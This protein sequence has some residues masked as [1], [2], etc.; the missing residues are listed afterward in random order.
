MGFGLR[1]DDEYVGDRRVG[2]PHF[3]TDEAIAVGDLFRTRLHARRIGAGVRLGQAEAADEFARGELRQVLLALLFRAVGED[4]IHDE[5]GLHRHHRAIA[6]VHRLDFAR[7]E[8]IADIAGADAAIFFRN[9]HA[10]QAEFAHFA[11][12]RGIGVLV[13]IGVDHARL[14]LFLRIGMR[15]VA[16]HALVFGQLIAEQEGVVPLE[17]GLGRVD[18][19]GAFLAR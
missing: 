19:H 4:G 7:D 10:E 13:E 17:A 18:V 1:P 12:D 2:N 16:D 9:G 11:E 15:G 5:R 3:R 14:K 8:A 6:G